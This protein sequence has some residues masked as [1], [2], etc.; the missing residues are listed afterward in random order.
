MNFGANPYT[1]ISA[2]ARQALDAIDALTGAPLAAAAARAQARLTDQ[3]PPPVE[4]G[5]NLATLRAR[6]ELDEEQD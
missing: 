3:T 2:R 1:S 6:L 4:H 5:A